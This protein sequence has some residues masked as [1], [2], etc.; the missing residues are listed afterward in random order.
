M[1]RPTIQPAKW[2]DAAADDDDDNK[3]FLVKHQG[4]HVL[5]KDFASAHKSTRNWRAGARVCTS[6]S[7]RDRKMRRKIW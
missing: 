6:A 1:E 7:E 5:Q 3:Y 4:P 2:W